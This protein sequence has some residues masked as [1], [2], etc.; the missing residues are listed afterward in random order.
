MNLKSLNWNTLERLRKSFLE[1]KP[2]A[3][4]Y[5]TRFE[6]LRDYDLTFAQRIAWKW[7]AVLAELQRI[8]WEP[9]RGEW[10]DWGCGSGIASR[11]AVPDLGGDTRREVGCFD[12]SGRAMRFATEA[13]TKEMLNARFE[14][15]KADALPPRKPLGLLLISHVLNELNEEQRASLVRLVR[16]SKAVIWVEP[17]SKDDSRA[18]S[19]VRDELLNE[20]NAVAPCTHTGPCG[21][22]R[23]ENDRHWCHFFTQAPVGVRGN[24]EWQGFAKR[25]GIDLRSLPYSYIVMENKLLKR[26]V[27]ETPDLSRVIGKPR[28]YKGTLKVLGCSDKELEDRE[29]QKRDVPDF[30]KDCRKGAIGPLYRFRI[31]GERI[32]GVEDGIGAEAGTEA[33]EE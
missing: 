32:K 17:G 28:V 13:A 19:G 5:W 26:E 15:V 11:R 25:L 33:A 22:L 10:L 20:F 12:R 4:D 24:I 31:E 16:R 21:M 23:R 1:A 3:G 29:A 6:D 7:D 2:D 30:F 8:G 27:R 18:L 9:P 14:T